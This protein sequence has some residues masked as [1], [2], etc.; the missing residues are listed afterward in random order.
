MVDLTSETTLTGHFFVGRFLSIN[1]VFKV[2]IKA[3]RFYLLL[4]SFLL[5]CVFQGVVHFTE[6]DEFIVIN[7]FIIL[8]YYYF[9]IF[10]IHSDISL[11]VSY[12]DNLWLSPFFLL[13]FLAAPRG[14]QDP[15]SPTRDPTRA[16]H[17]VKTR[18]PNHWTTRK[19]PPLL[20]LT[21]R[22]TDL[23]ILLIFLYCLSLLSLVIFLFLESTLSDIN[24]ATPSFFLLVFCMVYFFSILLLV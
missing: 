6:V 18:S 20:I 2:D 5:I 9:N 1:S 14:M 4:E 10:R 16:H 8:S 3:L 12:I 13:F 19:V 17:A 24:I 11:F 23:S 7:L 22:T 21:R 15:S